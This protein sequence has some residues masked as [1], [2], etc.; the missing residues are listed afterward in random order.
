MAVWL[1]RVLAQCI[2][3]SGFDPKISLH[4]T[5]TGHTSVILAFKGGKE[6]IEIFLEGSYSLPPLVFR[7]RFSLCNWFVI[8]IHQLKPESPKEQIHYKRIRNEPQ[9][10]LLS[11]LFPPSHFL[12]KQHSTHKKKI[13]LII[14]IWVYHNSLH[15]KCFAFSPLPSR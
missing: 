14:K 11:G 3:N 15:I 2:W 4:E 7:D 5:G 8:K 12:S 13:C 1:S 9:I 6:N 10:R